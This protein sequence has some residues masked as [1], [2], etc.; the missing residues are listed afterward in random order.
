MLG[1]LRSVNQNVLSGGLSHRLW[2]ETWSTSGEILSC[3]AEKSAKKRERQKLGDEEHPVKRSKQEQLLD[4]HEQYQQHLNQQNQQAQQDDAKPQKAGKKKHKETQARPD[5]EQRD[6]KMQDHD[7][8]AAAEGN[9]KGHEAAAEKGRPVF[10]DEHT[11]FVK[12]LGYDVHEEDL[13]KLFAP[14][15]GLKAIRM[16]TDR[17]TGAPRVSSRVQLLAH[18]SPALGIMDREVA[19]DPGHNM[20]ALQHQNC[21][22]RPQTSWRRAVQEQG[23]LESNPSFVCCSK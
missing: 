1:L 20:V 4:Q 19:Y 15:G 18:L 16:G 12:G 17:D 21:N 2:L 9:D 23:T 5:G 8:P 7:G 14:V 13:R 10:K 6:Q 11:V 22:D 3:V